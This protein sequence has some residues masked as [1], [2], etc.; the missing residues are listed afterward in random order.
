M[1]E[2]SDYREYSEITPEVLRDLAIELL[3]DIEERKRSSVEWVHQRLVNRKRD[4]IARIEE[5]RTKAAI[6]KRKDTERLIE[7]RMELMS[8]ALKDIKKAE[9]MQELITALDE[10][11]KATSKEIPGFKKWRA[12]AVHQVNSIDPRNMSVKRAGHWIEKFEFK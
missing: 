3:M 2:N 12:W 4:A 11:S 5:R 10:K 8:Q 9:K 1:S 6:R 7:K